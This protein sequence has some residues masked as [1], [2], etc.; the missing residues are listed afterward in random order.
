MLAAGRPGRLTSG[1]ASR[2]LTAWD[3]A[4]HQRPIVRHA[5]SLLMIL[6][7]RPAGRLCL[8]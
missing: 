4:R 7:R 1:R 5:K 6:I 3:C 2:Q 8:A